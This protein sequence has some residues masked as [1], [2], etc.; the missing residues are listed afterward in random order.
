MLVL[1]IETTCDETAAAV[2]ERSE[3]GGFRAPASWNVNNVAMSTTHD[4]PTI[5]GWWAGRDIDWRAK[6]DMLGDVDEAAQRTAREQD[7][8][9]LWRAVAP[10][11]NGSLPTEAPI[12]EVLGLLAQT[13]APLLILPIED[14]LGVVEQPNLP[15]TIDTHPNWRQRLDVPVEQLFADPSV[16]QRLAP[17][18]HTRTSP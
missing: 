16:V 3:D 18:L 6:L 13:P 14:V 9:A 2:I 7:K 11:Q 15:A 8:Q 17:I 1:G 5:A 10:Q 12:P 4:L